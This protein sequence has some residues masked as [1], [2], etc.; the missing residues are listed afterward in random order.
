MHQSLEIVEALTSIFSFGCCKVKTEN[1]YLVKDAATLRVLLEAKEDSLRCLRNP[2]ICCDCICW[3]GSKRPFTLRLAE[4]HGDPMVLKM[5]RP[6]ASECL[7]CCLQSLAVR[8]YTGLLG[9]VRQVLGYSQPCT[10]CAKFE[11]VEAKGEVQFFI[12]TPCVVTACCCNE[13]SFDITNTEGNQV[14]EI[15][16]TSSNVAKELFTD[17]DRFIAS[18][19]YSFSCSS[20]GS[21]SPSPRALTPT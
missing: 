8:D 21:S 4:Q 10:A 15:T 17:G 7:P 1:K 14:G 2:C 9:S 16:K 6:C 18:S 11:V 5:T 12:R 13:A 20:P 19:S 3:C